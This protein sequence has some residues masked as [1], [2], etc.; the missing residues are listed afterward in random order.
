MVVVAVPVR[1]DE[2]ADGLHRVRLDLR[3]HPAGGLR[4]V[5][6]IDYQDAVVAE[7]GDRVAADDG[8]VGAARHERHHPRR[9]LHRVVGDQRF[10]VGRERSGGQ[11]ECEHG[12]PRQAFR[13]S[14]ALISR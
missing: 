1:V 12:D 10:V 2:P 5:T 13:I 7:D 3:D 9:N 14:F 4:K 11:Q 6:G 8:G